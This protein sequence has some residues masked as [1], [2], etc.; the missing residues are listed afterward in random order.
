MATQDLDI[1]ITKTGV[2]AGVL[3]A[4]RLILEHLFDPRRVDSTLEQ[5]E[6]A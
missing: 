4:G 1:T 3:G 2:H 5:T 6:R